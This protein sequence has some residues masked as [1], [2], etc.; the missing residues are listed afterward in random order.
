M[1]PLGLPRNDSTCPRKHRNSIDFIEDFKGELFDCEQ[2]LEMPPD[3]CLLGVFLLPC[4]ASPL[5]SL[6]GSKSPLPFLKFTFSHA[7]HF[8][9]VATP[10]HLHPGLI[11]LRK[12]ETSLGGGEGGNK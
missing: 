5:P 12:K 6:L 1:A 10:L 11:I 2:L 3:F 8:G 9:S 7:K 4:T